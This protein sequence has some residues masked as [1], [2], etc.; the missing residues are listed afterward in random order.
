MKPRNPHVCCV[1]TT[2]QAPRPTIGLPLISR[3]TSRTITKSSVCSRRY[4]TVRPHLAADIETPHSRTQSCG[5]LSPWKWVCVCV[6]ACLYV[7]TNIL[8]RVSIECLHTRVACIRC[9]PR[10]FGARTHCPRNCKVP[11]Y[12]MS[13]SSNRPMFIHV[14]IP[15]AFTNS[16]YL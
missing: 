10:C 13:F 3:R 16:I 9:A 6:R 8:G 5:S 7:S 15:H 4:W 11:P 12:E 14:C 2:M 1:P